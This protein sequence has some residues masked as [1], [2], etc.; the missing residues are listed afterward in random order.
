E[1]INRMLFCC[2]LAPAQW[3]EHVRASSKMLS[4]HFTSVYRQHGQL[5]ME[6]VQ[7]R[8]AERLFLI[9]GPQYFIQ[10]L[11]TITLI[12]D[13]PG[14]VPSTN[15]LW[16]AVFERRRLLQPDHDYSRLRVTA[17]PDD[18]YEFAGDTLI[19]NWCDDTVRESFDLTSDS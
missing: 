16:R 5:Y 9:V 11:N 13:A 19:A 8:V 18:S 12:A 17:K 3:N 6:E 14:S 15:W 10:K 2:E 1:E 4:L 7:D